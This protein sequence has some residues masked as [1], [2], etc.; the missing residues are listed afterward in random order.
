MKIT[1]PYMGTTLA[2]KKFLDLLGH[3]TISPPKPNQRTFDLG[4]KYSPE[5]A[6]FPLKVITGSYLEAVE[7]GAEVI[8]TSGGHGPCRAGFGELHR[9][10]L[11][12]MGY[13]VDVIVIDSI[14]RDFKTVMQNIR[15]IK[16]KNSWRKLL[17]AARLT[18][19]LIKALDD[20]EMQIQTKAAYEV[21]REIAG[22]HGIKFKGFWKIFGQIGELEARR[23]D[24]RRLSI[25][26]RYGRFPKRKKYG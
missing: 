12:S 19:R 1:F 3:E 25:R 10:I 24:A 18:Y 16:G 14:R 13:D 21:S 7:Q 15:R 20:F 4:V 2:Y 11:H 22:E 8:V 23:K 5:F 9:K 17:W 26:Y 6:C